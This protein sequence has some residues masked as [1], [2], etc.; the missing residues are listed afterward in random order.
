MET[1]SDAILLKNEGMSGRRDERYRN[2]SFRKFP[3]PRPG[4]KAAG[5]EVA[6]TAQLGDLSPRGGTRM[7]SMR[8]IFRAEE[9]TPCQ[10]VEFD[11]LIAS[12]RAPR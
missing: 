8:G 12:T 5:A 10:I 2:A 3:F 1:G 11:F 9:R 4:R 7:K 6:R